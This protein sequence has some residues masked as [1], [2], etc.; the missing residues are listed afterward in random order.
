MIDAYKG[1]GDHWVEATILETRTEEQEP[2]RSFKSALVAYRVYHDGGANSDGRGTFD[3]WDW[4]HDEWIPLMSRRI[5]PHFTKFTKNQAT[6]NNE[7]NKQE[8]LRFKTL[9]P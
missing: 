9:R 2:N 8:S 1:K 6:I 3:G 5:A 4:T 7:D